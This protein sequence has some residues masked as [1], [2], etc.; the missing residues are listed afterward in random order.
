LASPSP[1]SPIINALPGENQNF[2][3]ALSAFFDAKMMGVNK[4]IPASVVQYNRSTNVATVQPQ[5]MLVDTMGG[6]GMRK[7]I[8]SVPV[9]SLGGGGFHI[10]FPL[11]NGNLGWILA[12]DKDISAFLG[13]LTPAPPNT[14]R[15]HRF[16][17]SWFI[18]DVFRQYTIAS[19]NEN[20][21]VI[22]STDGT[23]VISIVE[24]VINITAPTSVTVTTPIATFSQ[25][26]QVDGNLIVTGNTTVNGGFN[27]SGSSGDE[28]TLPAN[29]TIDGITVATHGHDGVQTGTSRTGGGMVT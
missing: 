22:Q 26:V 18:P 1:N 24:G 19:A 9:L 10:N 15:R 4:L 27:A 3:A 12:A 2:A 17:D 7:Q 20:A 29:T 11:K 5:I 16:E 23:T 21:M 8:A 14:F 6:T 13:N 28:V 25:N